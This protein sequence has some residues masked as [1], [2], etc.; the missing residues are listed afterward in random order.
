MVAGD[1]WKAEYVTRR[2]SSLSF[3]QK[4]VLCHSML[5]LFNSSYNTI[6]CVD[7]NGKTDV[8]GDVCGKE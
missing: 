7:C 1:V 8:H 3:A 5:G 6:M 4:L 2:Q